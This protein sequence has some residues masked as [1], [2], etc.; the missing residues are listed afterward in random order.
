MGM[1][2]EKEITPRSMSHRIQEQRGA[3][4]NKEGVVD[5]VIEEAQLWPHVKNQTPA[6]KKGVLVTPGAQR[7]LLTGRQ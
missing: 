1:C 5:L 6:S 3:A 2:L 7:G 4:L